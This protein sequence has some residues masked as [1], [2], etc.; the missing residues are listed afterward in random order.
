MYTSV[1]DALFFTWLRARKVAFLHNLLTLWSSFSLCT[2][3]SVFC[4]SVLNCSD[5]LKQLRRRTGV[6]C[7]LVQGSW[8]SLPHFIHADMH[9]HNMQA[10]GWQCT[11]KHE[12]HTFHLVIQHCLPQMCILPKHTLSPWSRTTD[13]Q[14][15]MTLW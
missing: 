10:P 4:V 2:W 9:G 13:V 7:P 8:L 12:H 14:H 6:T 15:P 1:S 3:S 11:D 5:T